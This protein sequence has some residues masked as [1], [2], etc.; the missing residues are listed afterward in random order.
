MG[1]RYRWL[2]YGYSENVRDN[3]TAVVKRK[4][5]HETVQGSKDWRDWA[6]GPRGCAMGFT[7]LNDDDCISRDT[8]RIQHLAPTWQLVY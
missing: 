4:G 1:I 7:L 8:N 5:L 3:P 6:L 2:V